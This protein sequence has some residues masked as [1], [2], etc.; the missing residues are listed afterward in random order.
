MG[1]ATVATMMRKTYTILAVAFTATTAACGG[2]A[3]E[4]PSHQMTK[5]ELAQELSNMPLEDALK[6]REHFAPLCD[7]DGYPLPGNIN[8]KETGAKVSQ[9][10]EA[11]TPK[12]PETKPDQP[13]PPPQTKP[14]PTPPAPACDKDALNQELSSSPLESALTQPQHYR[15][16]C[17]DKGYP[18][19]GNINSKGT[20]AS[21]FCSALKEKGLL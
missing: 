4:A 18:L 9:F 11:I 17:D 8:N 14:V 21:A 15:C 2:V 1:V 7:G 6:N 12:P 3:S 16:L 19:V 20:T 10:C 13:A 5:Q